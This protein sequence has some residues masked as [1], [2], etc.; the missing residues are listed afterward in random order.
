MASD[1]ITV[2]L[3]GDST[4]AEKA[5]SERPETGWGTPFAERVDDSVTVENHA[6]NGRST[7]TFLEEGRW[8]PVVTALEAG[9][10]V[11]VQFGHNDEVP[12]K[13]QYTPEAEFEANLER[14]VAET[15]ERGAEVVLLTPLARRHF[16]EEGIPEDT[17]RA[18]SELT[19]D[20]ARLHDVPLVD[21]DE[22]SRSLLRELGPEESESLY[23]HLS[24]GEHPNYPDGVTDDT[25]FS[26]AG[27]RRMADLILDGVEALDL[28][29][30]T[31]LDRDSG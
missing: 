30:A 31:R 5:A 22:R 12:S 9:D 15:R 10:Y 18:Y 11:F 17:H 26:E 20:V 6:R 23:N 4:A 3:I 13:E 1:P 8:H 21:A 27:A 28:G 19:R 2:H 14:F 25:H 29:L 24:P 16:G 7:R